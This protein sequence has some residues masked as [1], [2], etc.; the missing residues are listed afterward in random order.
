[1]RSDPDLCVL[2]GE[3]LSASCGWKLAICHCLLE[4]FFL[5][6]CKCLEMRGNL[7]TKEMAFQL[8]NLCDGLKGCENHNTPLHQH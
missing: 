4:I 6:R 5:Q 8:L 1:M 7:R 3:N 2:E